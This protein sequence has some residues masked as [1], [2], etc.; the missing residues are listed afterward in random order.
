[1][2]YKDK[3]AAIKLFLEENFKGIKVKAI[4][5]GYYGSGIRREG[6][7][8]LYKGFLKSD[9]AGLPV[10]LP[11]WVKPVDMKNYKA[12]VEYI[13]SKLGK[14]EEGLKPFIELVEKSKKVSAKDLE[15]EEEEQKED[16]DV[17][18][19][20]VGSEEGSKE[21]SEEGSKESSEGIV[22]VNESN[23]PFV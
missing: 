2:D 21:S 7:Q 17:D 23:N 3:V 13:E 14:S 1:M 18:Y 15:V 16:E 10:L 19:S 22:D 6:E 4:A 12:L 5:D 9:A 20:S 8:F 11:A